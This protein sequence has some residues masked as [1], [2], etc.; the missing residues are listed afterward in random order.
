MSGI[1]GIVQLDG[2]P[3]DRSL[4]NRMT[5]YLAFRGPDARGVWTGGEAGLG[6]SLLRTTEEAEHEQRP[7]T[8]DGLVWITA[9]ARVDGRAELIRELRAGGRDCPASTTDPELILH[10]YGLWG[11]RAVEHLIGDF[12]F[13]IW[14]SRERKLFCARDHFGVK[15]FFYAQAGGSLVFSNTLDCIRIA[16]GIS[17]ELDEQF[18]ADLLLFEFSLD[19]HRTAFQAIRRLPPGHTLEASRGEVRIRRYWSLPVEGPIRYRRPEEYVEH[20]R[21]LFEQAVEDRLRTRRVVMQMSGGLDSTFVAAVAKKVFARSGQP[22]ELSAET[23]VYDELFPDE[24]RR[25]ATMAAEALAIP[26]DCVPSDGYR[27][28]ERWQEALSRPE[29]VHSPLAVAGGDW[30]KR[31]ASHARVTLTGLGGDPGFSSLLSRHCREL[32]R[33]GRLDRLALDLARYL[34]EEG[35]A[36]RMYWRA[37]WW[38]WFGRKDPDRYYP[39]W[40]APEFERRLDLRARY[41]WGRRPEVPAGA[42]RPEAYEALDP[43]FWA[44]LFEG[45]DPGSTSLSLEARHPFF[46]TRVLQYL[47]R[48]PTLPW[49][50]DKKLLR[51]AMRG[52][53]PDQLR[54]RK[55]TPLGA[56]PILA[57]LRRYGLCEAGEVQPEPELGRFV[58]WGKIPPIAAE[59]DHGRLCVNLRPLSLNYWLKCKAVF[60]YN[61][62]HKEGS[63]ESFIADTS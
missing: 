16:P 24:E 35:R 8:L 60:V 53:L 57:S 34:M 46:D 26:I 15:P 44:W 5:V 40:L 29:P 37:R 12:S 43:A 13:A 30:L 48:L 38:R 54:L 47:L 11:E 31:I 55:K 62:Q 28:Y 22:F 17:D 59:T 41:R 19:L 1:A 50:S 2:A 56:D 42:G 51:E 23:A 63:R 14:D 49:C 9:D 61:N 27:L 25:Y 52:L 39:K 32:V 18:I 33:Q 45:Y 3:I 4:I 20:F 10:A 21:E 7:A 6:Q 36:S 58:L